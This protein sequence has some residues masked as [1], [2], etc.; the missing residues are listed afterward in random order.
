LGGIKEFPLFIYPYSWVLI[1][2]DILLICFGERLKQFFTTIPWK[3]LLSS[4]LFHFAVLEGF[5][6]AIFS[7][8][9]L[10]MG[11]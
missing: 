3:N 7:R 5:V 4:K 10:E 1:F 8:Y 11:T 9:P 2:S 6:E